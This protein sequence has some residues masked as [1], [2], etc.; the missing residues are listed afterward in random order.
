MLVLG[1][2]VLFEPINGYQIRR[3]LGTWGVEE[4]ADMKAGSIYSMLT[5][6]EREASLRR[7]D[8]PETNTRS[9]AVYESTEAG[10]TEFRRLVR[11]GL[12]GSLGTDTT[13]F[14]TA[15]SFLPFATRSEALTALRQRRERLEAQV[16]AL[17]VKVGLADQK[18]LPP[19]VRHLL[20]LDRDLKEREARWLGDFIALIGDGS[21]AFSG[22]VAEEWA[23]PPDDSGWE[24]VEQSRRYREQIA[25]L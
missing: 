20:A 12:D 13:T 11:G 5:T 23:P 22:E 7:W 4:W 9:V 3:E 2:V 21:L 15:M 16:A 19:H 18:L 8:L 6:L 1:V 10:R 24:M 14:Q 17:E 25:A